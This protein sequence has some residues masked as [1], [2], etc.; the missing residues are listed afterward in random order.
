MKKIG[1]S[2]LMIL[3]LAGCVRLRD[4]EEEKISNKGSDLPKVKSSAEGTS[5]A[6]VDGVLHWTDE[7]QS[8]W[9]QFK[10]PEGAQSIRRTDVSNSSSIYLIP[11]D[12]EFSDSNLISEHQYR[13]EVL[14]SSGKGLASYEALIPKDLILNEKIFVESSAIFKAARIYF[15]S[16]FSLYTNGNQVKILA[17]QLFVSTGARIVSFEKK[18]NAP[19]GVSGRDGGRLEIQAQRSLGRLSIDLSGEA[20]GQGLQG[21][22][23]PRA[24][25]GD[26]GRPSRTIGAGPNREERE[27]PATLG[28]PGKD[29]VRGRDGHQGGEGGNSGQLFAEIWNH[30]QFS[31]EFV[32]EAGGGGAPGPGGF[33]QEGGHGGRHGAGHTQ[34]TDYAPNGRNGPDGNDG[35]P[36]ESGKKLLSCLT[37]QGQMNCF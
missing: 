1:F 8:Y 13:Y 3:V 16:Q 21:E 7:A 18:A 6:Y 10:V 27:I 28:S 20:G 31:L 4:K 25:S 12:P 19:Q 35:P 36:G 34:P 11:S 2:C 24:Q 37:F 23:W 14:D 15:G 30:Q 32:S 9:V 22:A 33:G 5:Q 26:S 17:D 29:G